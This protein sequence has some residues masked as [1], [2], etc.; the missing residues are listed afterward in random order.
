LDLRDGESTEPSVDGEVQPFFGED[1]ACFAT[2]ELP[3]DLSE[4]HRQPTHEEALRDRHTGDVVELLRDHGDP[5]GARLD[6]ALDPYFFTTDSD[7]AGVWLVDAVD[8]LHQ[9]RFAGTVLTAQR[10]N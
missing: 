5:M 9:G 10:M 3:V 6:R 1:P 7:G 8:D 4:F 2:D